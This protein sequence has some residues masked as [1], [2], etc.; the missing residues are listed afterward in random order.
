MDKDMLIYL[1]IGLAIGFVI[2]FI[3]TSIIS[4]KAR[5][6]AKV[7]QELEQTKDELV[8]QKQMI[9]KHFSHSAE[10]LDNMAKDF[11]RLY[12]HMAE[13]SSQFIDNDSVSSLDFNSVLD[14]DEPKEIM[15]DE[16]PRDY[17]DNSSG[18]FKTDENKS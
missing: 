12:Q 4:P 18:L 11:R 13:N 14:S 10:I 7:K 2:G 5:K 8:A 1:I 15:F 6:Y 3:F 17:S 16:Q 9:A